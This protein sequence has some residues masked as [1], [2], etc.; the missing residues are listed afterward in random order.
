MP[1]RDSGRKILIRCFMLSSFE[2]TLPRFESS[3]LMSYLVMGIITQD[4]IP[5]SF[6]ESAGLE[7]KKGFYV[8]ICWTLEEVRK[9][10]AALGGIV[11]RRARFS[12][13]TAVVWV[14]S[15]SEKIGREGPVPCDK[16]DELSRPIM[17]SKS[18]LLYD[19]I[20]GAA[21]DAI[22]PTPLP[23]SQGSLLEILSCTAS[24]KGNREHICLRE[25]NCLF[26]QLTSF[27]V[28]QVPYMG[29]N[30]TQPDVMSVVQRVLNVSGYWAI[31]FL[32]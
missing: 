30:S 7:R 21:I 11:K 5:D 32:V 9:R 19:F 1:R 10:E 16:L 27:L 4:I 2:S 28:P 14:F 31:G 12:T 17:I 24:G 23:L 3:T 22:I 25:R 13:G 15:E 8:L 26:G 18:Y 6:A 29:S 20:C